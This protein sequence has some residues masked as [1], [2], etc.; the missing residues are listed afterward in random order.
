MMQANKVT[1]CLVLSC[2]VL[3]YMQQSV[4]TSLHQFAAAAS[5]SPSS[6]A[7]LIKRKRK[8]LPQSNMAISNSLK[9][10]IV[11]RG[12]TRREKKEQSVIK[13]KQNNLWLGLGSLAKE[14][15]KFTKSGLKYKRHLIGHRVRYVGFGLFY[16]TGCG[17]RSCREEGVIR[18]SAP[19]LKT[20]NELH[21]IV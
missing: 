19:T 8:Y 14:A 9:S 17:V 11:P 16:F 13:I 10:S 6:S 4:L 1:P 21:F 2:L 15:L 18:S 7:A 3:S 12:R 5:A 20:C